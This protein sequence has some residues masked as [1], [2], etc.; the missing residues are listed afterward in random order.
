[1]ATPIVSGGIALLLQGT[2]SLSPA[3][4]KLAIQNGAT[5]MTDGGLMGAGTGSVN[6]L[7]SRKIAANGL[8]NVTTT[9]TGV[10]IPSSGASFWDAGTLSSRLYQGIGI[11]LIDALTASLVWLNP[12]LLNFGDLNLLGLTNPLQ[13]VMPKYLQYGAVAGYT[14]SQQIIWGTQITDPSGQQIIWG[15]GSSTDD[16]QIIWG[17]TLTSADAQ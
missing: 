9:I 1:M 17:T 7:A 6:F 15:T 16:Q 2:P 3:Q 5:Y 11:R 4:V 13:S 10:L 8:L 12:S 14:P